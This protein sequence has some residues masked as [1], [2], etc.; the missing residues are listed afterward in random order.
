MSYVV[1]LTDQAQA[2]LA[3][4]PSHLQQFLE[5]RLVE[6]SGSPSRKSRRS[7]SPPYPPDVMLYE[8]DYHVAG[9]RWHFTVF[10][11]YSQD[12]TSLIV[13]GIGVLRL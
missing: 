1:Q 10:F 6:L 3:A 12:E 4:L 9:E 8:V 5:A 2:D 7:V 13:R 11:R